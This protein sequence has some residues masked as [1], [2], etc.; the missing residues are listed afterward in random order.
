MVRTIGKSET[1]RGPGF[2]DHFIGAIAMPHLTERFP[3]LER[4]VKLPGPVE[5]ATGDPG[6]K[7]SRRRLRKARLAA[8]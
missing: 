5:A 1:A 8:G 7:I 4:Q 6:P 3:N 2:Q